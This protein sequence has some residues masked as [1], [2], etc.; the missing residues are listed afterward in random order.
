MSEPP[1]A[2]TVIPRSCAVRVVATAL[3]LGLLLGAYSA[4]GDGIDAMVINGLANAAGPWIITAFLAGI[5]QRS[6][7]AG[8]S[9]GALTLATAVA[10]YY[11]GVLIGGHS[12]P[13][14]FV[15]AW[16]AVAAP[17]GALFGLAGSWCAIAGDRWRTAAAILVSSAL[18]AEAAHRLMA[19]R[20]WTGIEWDR[21]YTQVATADALAAVAVLLIL[22]ERRRWLV[23]LAMLPPV[24]G[25]GLLLFVVA[26][27]ILGWVI[28]GR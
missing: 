28:A 10:A 19:L 15:V 1:D 18:L 2:A 13:L 17:S 26:G 25:I 8:G 9:A 27:G 7:R 6:T 4:V 20:A 5:V 3:P 16:L 21:T 24:T 22:V 23:A 11:G 14:P 12:F